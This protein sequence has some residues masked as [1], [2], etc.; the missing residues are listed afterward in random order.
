MDLEVY[1]EQI[2]EMRSIAKMSGQNNLVLARHED[3]GEKDGKQ[4]LCFN[5]SDRVQMVVLQAQLTDI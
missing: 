3:S 1:S 2:K 4:I 5:T